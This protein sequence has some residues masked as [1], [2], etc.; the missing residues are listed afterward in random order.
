MRSRLQW[1][2]ARGD[3]LT[4]GEKISIERVARRCGISS[5]KQLHAVMRRELGV[6]PTEYRR[7]HAQGDPRP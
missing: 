6:G 7:R 3:L 4:G 1:P 5:A 2:Y